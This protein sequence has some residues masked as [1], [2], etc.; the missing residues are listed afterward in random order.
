MNENVNLF[1]KAIRVLFLNEGAKKRT[2]SN[3]FFNNLRNIVWME[4]QLMPLVSNLLDS[5]VYEGFLRWLEGTK[6]EGQLEES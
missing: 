4:M 1:Y 6:D 5:N 2:N 3:A